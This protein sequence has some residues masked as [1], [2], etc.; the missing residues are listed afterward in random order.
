LFGAH[1]LF[2]DDANSFGPGFGIQLAYGWTL[3]RF[4]EA[5]VGVRFFQHE[6]TG[7]NLKS[8]ASGTLLVIQPTIGLRAHLRLAKIWDIGLGLH[9]GAGIMGVGNLSDRV[10]GL[11]ALS[12]FVSV[13]PHPNLALGVN[14]APTLVMAKLENGQLGN[15]VSL[16]VFASIQLRF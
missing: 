14:V 15:S 12:A 16:P 4:F 5:S 10:G 9:M 8:G 2:G 6:Y 1:F 3:S 7:S 11:A 13:N